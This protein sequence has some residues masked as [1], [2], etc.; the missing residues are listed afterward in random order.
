MTDFAL[1]SY[2]GSVERS[3]EDIVKSSRVGA[4]GYIE[5]AVYV[6]GDV[7]PNGATGKPMVRANLLR[8]IQR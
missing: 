8:P 5:R 3:Y 4:D 6:S 1:A 7:I 2:E